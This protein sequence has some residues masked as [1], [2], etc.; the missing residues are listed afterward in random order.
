MGENTDTVEIK[1]NT[2]TDDEGG[3]Y[4]GQFRKVSLKKPSSA[5]IIFG[6]QVYSYAKLLRFVESFSSGIKKLFSIKKGDKVLI[7][8]PPGLPY[9]IALLSMSRIGTIAIPLEPYV[10]EKTFLDVLSKTSPSGII[11]PD[12]LLNKYE[13][14][15]SSEIFKIQV[16]TNEFLT[17]RNRKQFGIRTPELMKQKTRVNSNIFEGLCYS[18]V[19]GEETIDPITDFFIERV[20]KSGDKKTDLARF[21]Y[22]NIMSAIK[23]EGNLFRN[24]NGAEKFLMECETYSVAAITIGILFPLLKGNCIIFDAPENRNG[25]AKLVKWFQPEIV[26]LENYVHEN[27]DTLMKYTRRYKPKHLVL[28][29]SHRNNFMISEIFSGLKTRVTG[30]KINGRIS[31]PICSLESVDISSHPLS[32]GSLFSGLTGKPAEANGETNQ[33]SISGSQV[34]RFFEK[35]EMDEEITP[36]ENRVIVHGKLIVDRVELEE[37]TFE[38][39]GSEIYVNGLSLE[40]ES[41]LRTE[42]GVKGAVLITKEKRS[43]RSNII[44]IESDSSK[45]TAT[46]ISKVL[47]FWF[48]RF[49]RESEI[50]IV[51]SIPRSMSGT[52]ILELIWKLL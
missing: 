36:D 51:E 6:G 37:E 21:T 46:D 23:N 9:T 40:V 48:P 7:A 29:Q 4:F 33:I 25:M 27:F 2:F 31:T 28:I 52:P 16:S 14:N 17:P 35:T 30:I 12:G 8:L 19:T 41:Q 3:D 1:E 5:A 11:A 47:A 26:I 13:K 50:R 34:C 15:I 44:L 49:I 45:I 18:E 42:T 38:S 43:E 24:N 22:F 39:G 32:D 20:V 10:P